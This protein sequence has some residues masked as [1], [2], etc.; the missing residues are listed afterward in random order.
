LDPGHF[1]WNF[2]NKDATTPHRTN[3]SLA[4]SLLQVEGRG[5]RRT[6]GAIWADRM[7]MHVC[8]L[9]LQCGG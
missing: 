8:I 1:D 2:E 7:Q 6:G 4:E 5:G 3:G 9:R